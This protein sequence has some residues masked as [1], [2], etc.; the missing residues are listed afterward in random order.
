M[1]YDASPSGPSFRERFLS[2]FRITVRGEMTHF[3]VNGAF[4][5]HT[6]RPLINVGYP[7]RWILDSSN[8]HRWPSCLFLALILICFDPTALLP[9]PMLINRHF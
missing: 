7:D 5:A 1:R 9:L 6:T 3:L 4:N 8:I 2:F